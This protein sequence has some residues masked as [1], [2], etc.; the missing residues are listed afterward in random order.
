MIWCFIE[1]SDRTDLI[2]LNHEINFGI[3]L[4]FVYVRSIFIDAANRDKTQITHSILKEQLNQSKKVHI[5]VIFVSVKY[6]IIH[7]KCVAFGVFK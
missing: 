6:E 4:L 7:T 3:L 5:P 1:T 2:E